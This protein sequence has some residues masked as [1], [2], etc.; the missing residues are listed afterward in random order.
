VEVMVQVSY[1]PMP[2][3]PAASE[4]RARM[5]RAMMYFNLRVHCCHCQRARPWRRRFSRPTDERRV[6]RGAPQ[7]LG[8]AADLYSGARRCASEPH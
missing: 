8:A 3:A 5:R 6:L 2:E 1:V 7:S 4:M